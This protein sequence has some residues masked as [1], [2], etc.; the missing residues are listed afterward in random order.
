LNTD[1]RGDDF[2]IAVKNYMARGI[3]LDGVVRLTGLRRSVARA[4]MLKLEAQRKAEANK[5]RVCRCGARTRDCIQ[6]E[7]GDLWC[8]DCR[9]GGK[10]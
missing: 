4:L 7:D 6:D 3:D 9:A 10:F 1:D 8:G 5:L 2:A